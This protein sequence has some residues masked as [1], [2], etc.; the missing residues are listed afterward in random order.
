MRQQ[1][2]EWP[3]PA[4]AE[5]TPRDPW[6]PLL[7]W[8]DYSTGR[9]PRGA[10]APELAL[11]LVPNHSTRELPAGT[12]QVGL[13]NALHTPP[14]YTVQGNKKAA[15]DKHPP[16][17]WAVIG[18]LKIA[19]F[20]TRDDSRVG[21]LRPA[22]REVGSRGM[23]RE[24]EA[25]R[26]SDPD[27]SELNHSGAVQGRSEVS[28]GWVGGRS[29]PKPPEDRLTD[30]LQP[31]EPEPRARTPRPVPEEVRSS[32]NTA[33]ANSIS[34]RRLRRGLSDPPELHAPPRHRARRVSIFA[35]NPCL[36]SPANRRP[37]PSL[38]N[39]RSSGKGEHLLPGLPSPRSAN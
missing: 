22:S 6:C 34:G 2:G 9:G 1:P 31:L 21:Q 25:K 13:W 32:A 36:A 17:H 28:E 15:R 24:Q 35:F 20:T 14:V 18:R 5:V 3:P 19:L 26:S 23:R 10:S 16:P 30:Q 37:L 39:N 7:F 11:H 33:Q 8:G 29:H 4:K 27:S 12:P 38:R